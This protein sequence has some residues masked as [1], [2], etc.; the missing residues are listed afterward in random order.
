MRGVERHDL[1]KRLQASQLR[2]APFDLA[3]LSKLGV[4]PQLAAKYVR[5]RWLV[6]L[7][8]GVYS[9]PGDN[10]DEHRTIQFLRTKIAGLHFGG[11]SALAFHGVRHNLASRK[12]LV[13]WGK[14]RSKLPEWL[15][16]RFPARYISARL[17][18]WP[19]KMLA[20]TTLITPP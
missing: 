16:S 17:F 13:L 20:K 14:E 19:D 12:L 4:S 11:K 7:A 8:Q 5:G 6:R 15:L 10:L 18:A 9:F 3:D 2:G 1:I